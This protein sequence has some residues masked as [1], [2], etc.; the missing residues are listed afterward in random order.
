MAGL[1]EYAQWF[2]LGYFVL[3]QLG[4]IVLNLLS[5]GALRKYLERATVDHPGVVFSGLEPP[6]TVVMAAYNEAATIVS[7]LRSLLQLNYPEFEIVVINDGSTD[8]TLDIL[9]REFRLVAYPETREPALQ[10]RTVRGYYRS[11]LRPNLRVIDKENGGRADALNAGINIGEYPLFCA[12]DA[13]SVL[14]RDSLFLVV[15]P[16]LNDPD[17]VAAGGT[18]RV[19][20]GCEVRD[21]F[22]AKVGLPRNPL[23]LFQIVEYLRA[24]LFGRIGWNSINALLIISGAFGVFRRNVVVAAGGYD[25]VTLGEDMELTVRLHRI[26]RAKGKPYR[27]TFVP[28]P[29]CW[30]EVPQDLRTLGRQRARWHRG[31]SESLWANRGLL[32]SGGAVGWIAFPYAV[33][34]EWLAPLVELAGYVFMAAAWALGA[35]LGPAFLAFLAAAVGMG[36][37]VSVTA[38]LLEEMTFHVYPRLRHFWLL[39]LVAV[40]E[41][42]GF[43]Q[44]TTIW[45][46]NGLFQWLFRRKAVWGVMKRTGAWQKS[47]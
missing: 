40:V 31:L 45:R 46:L 39:L 44:L 9:K 13:D 11:R 32:A 42:L 5:F 14:Q 6:I 26:L 28:D 4:Y 17:I 30:T 18:I 10:T 33:V 36:V 12:I 24:F 22:L 8:A 15:Q 3:L 43:R 47:G 21:G 23:A 27:L 2:F 25:P 7:A 38:L 20:N 19:A 35:M 29:V 41:N 16:L 1:I 34:F 37:L